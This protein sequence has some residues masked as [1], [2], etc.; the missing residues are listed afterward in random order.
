MLEVK[1]KRGRIMTEKK[2]TV[3]IFDNDLRCKIEKHPISKN[4]KQIN[5]YSGGTGHFMPKF[6]NTSYLEF[7]SWKK[8]LLFGE[9]TY[10]RT[11]VTA[12]KAKKCVNFKTGEVY[13]PSPEELDNAVGALIA[14]KIGTEGITIPWYISLFLVLNL[15]LSIIIAG[16]LGVF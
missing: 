15:L 7:P 5:I 13:G 14:T 12:N 10:K 16:V 1:S 9:R 4:G 2:V 3:A 6:D 11:Y 8:Y